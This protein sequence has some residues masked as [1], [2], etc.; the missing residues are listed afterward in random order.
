M[1]SKPHSAADVHSLLGNQRRALVIGYLA[2]FD[3]GNRLL[4][5]MLPELLERSKLEQPPIA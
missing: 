1:N 3:Q 4:S 5:N 2:L